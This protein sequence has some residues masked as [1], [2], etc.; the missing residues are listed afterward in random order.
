M[1]RILAFILLCSPAVAGEAIVTGLSQNK[2]QITADFT[3]SDI[4]VY[5]AVKRDA[6]APTGTPLEVI[7]TL[8]GPSTPIIVRRKQ[9]V[10]GIWV[11]GD[12]VRIGAAPSFYAVTTTG[13]LDQILNKNEDLR[14][15]ITLSRSISTT[16]ISVE[17]MD[18][19]LF[20]Q[21]LRRI[22]ASQDRYRI[23]SGTVQLVEDTL[24]RTD[25]ALPANVTEG[26]Y[27]VRLFILRQGLVIDSQERVINV[28]KTGIERYLYNLAH[29]QPLLYGIISL[30]MAAIAGW[31]A[32]EIFRFAR[33]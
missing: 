29:Q 28:R 25:F 15:G 30:L 11:N 19:P 26:V 4:L 17:T 14:Y 21:A 24:F 1:I 12:A 20:T 5:G 33:R 31:A 10:A 22:R 13:P 3:G 8:E 9:R 18:F 23:S 6:P 32:S 27:T 7:V 2:V 16:E